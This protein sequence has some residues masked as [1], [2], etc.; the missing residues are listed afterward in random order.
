MAQSAR[1][2]PANYPGTLGIQILKA[3]AQ[4]QASMLRQE[5]VTDLLSILSETR[6]TNVRNR[7]IKLVEAN[8]RAGLTAAQKAE[9]SWPEAAEAK[10]LLENR[11][12]AKP[13]VA[14]KQLKVFEQ[15]DRV[16]RRSLALLNDSF[17]HI[18]V[19]LDRLQVPTA[20]SGGMDS[21]GRKS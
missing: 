8:L 2:I 18:R 9:D 3:E 21:L 5:V 19:I 12:D 11:K 17:D 14:R 6:E 7:L 20:T 1:T 13:A 4:R 15:C 16:H 10:E